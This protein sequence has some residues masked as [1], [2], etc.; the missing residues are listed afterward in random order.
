MP[1]S[2]LEFTGGGEPFLNK[3]LNDIIVFVKHH[4]PNTYSKLYTN[5]FI[6]KPVSQVDEINISRS[7]WDSA[8]N[9]KIYK[10]ALQNNL[11]EAVSFFK[12]F[13]IKIRTC[14]VLEQGAIDSEDKALAMIMALPEVDQ[15]VFRPMNKES[16]LLSYIDFDISHPKALKD[17]IDCTCHKS[18]VLAPNGKLYYDFNLSEEIILPD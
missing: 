12:Q 3:N 18:L 13:C 15:F 11:K 7:H 6:L 17:E 10:S 9:K 16:R 2:K 5:G 14:T 4:F 1:I 8:I